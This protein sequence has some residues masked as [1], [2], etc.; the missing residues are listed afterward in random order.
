MGT[1]QTTKRTALP[2]QSKPVQNQ[3][4]EACG[5]PAGACGASAGALLGGNAPRLE[6]V[7][8]VAEDLGRHVA[9]GPRLTRQLEFGV[10][11]VPGVL[12]HRQRLAQPEVGQLDCARVKHQALPAGQ[13]SASVTAHLSGH[14]KADP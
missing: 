12:V 4:I 10:Q 9:V 3:Q 11:V 6:V 5:Q 14:A 7:G 8:L 13:G 1:R 2:E